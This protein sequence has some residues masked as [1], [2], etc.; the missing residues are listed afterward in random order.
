MIYQLD[1]F[2]CVSMLLCRFAKTGEMSSAGIRGHFQ[3]YLLTL[4]H[5][6]LKFFCLV[7]TKL[8]LVIC[9]WFLFN[10]CFGVPRNTNPSIL[11]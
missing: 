4:L 5:L 6:K 8:S 10:H 2:G 7:H 11:S 3:Q 1:F 9:W